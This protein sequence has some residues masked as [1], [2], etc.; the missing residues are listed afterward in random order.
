MTTIHSE[1]IDACTEE[2]MPLAFALE[3]FNQISDAA[4]QAFE[5]N[6]TVGREKIKEAARRMMSVHGEDIN[7]LEIEQ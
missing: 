5:L 3:A 4:M 2:G 7:S 1:F 6:P